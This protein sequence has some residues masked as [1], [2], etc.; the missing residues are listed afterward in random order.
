MFNLAEARYGKVFSEAAQFF[1]QIAL[2]IEANP[3]FIEK[4]Y[5]KPALQLLAQ[6]DSLSCLYKVKLY[7]ALA[8]GDLGVLFAC[9]RPCLTGLLLR[10]IGSTEQQA[11]YFN[12]IK[13]KQLKSFFA[14]TEPE[15]G[16][17]VT[18]IQTTLT[19]A[20][21]NPDLFLLNGKKWLFGNA[22]CGKIGTVI[23]KTHHSILGINAVLL[24]IDEIPEQTL[25]RLPLKMAG[26]N[27]AQLGYV[28]FHNVPVKKSQLIGAHLPPLQRGMVGL[29]HTLNK[30]RVCIGALAVGQT[31][32]LIDYLLQSY[33]KLNSQAFAF[34]SE[35]EGIRALVLQTAELLDQE[36]GSTSQASLAKM[37]ST[38]YLEAITL[39]IFELCEPEALVSSPW[40]SKV[41][42]DAFALEYADGTTDI[43]EKNIYAGWVANLF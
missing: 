20:P 14:V 34:N 7:E 29:I 43:Q 36:P 32:A 16:S 17:D 22:I 35:L 12:K 21:N 31:Q 41:L 1:R 11:Y 23:A 42:R 27:A 2:E 26:L 33:P 25:I 37:T 24:N 13:H 30:M 28:E 18:A 4:Y 38:H 8:Y 5:D 3:A 39:R 6:D 15:F 40:L 9:P 19:Q 10:E